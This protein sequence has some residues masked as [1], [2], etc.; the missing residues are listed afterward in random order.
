MVDWSKVWNWLVKA[1]KFHI[2]IPGYVFNKW[3]FRVGIGLI[4]IWLLLAA[5]D[6][7]WDWNDKPYFICQDSVKCDNPWFAPGSLNEFGW[8]SP[9]VNPV[10]GRDPDLALCN[11]EFFLPG[12]FYGRPPSFLMSHAGDFAWVVV[13][14]MLL[15]NHFLFNKGF[16][17]QKA[18]ELKEMEDENDEGH[19]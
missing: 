10:P 3:I 8:I 14:L 17:K 2:E 16:F 7:G 6:Y 5:V 9:C 12:E 11:K 15:S 13:A 18:K 4:F 1:W 19:N